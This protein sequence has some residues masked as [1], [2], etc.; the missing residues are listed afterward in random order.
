MQVV[1]YQF[2]NQCL[3]FICVV[4]R[5]L[6]QKN[7]V[8]IFRYFILSVQGFLRATLSTDSMH[9]KCDECIAWCNQRPH[10]MCQ[11]IEPTHHLSMQE[12]INACAIHSFIC[13]SYNTPGPKSA[14]NACLDLDAF[15][16]LRFILL[17]LHCRVEKEQHLVGDFIMSSICPFSLVSCSFKD[18]LIWGLL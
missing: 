17:L 5:R 14:N 9:V 10:P 6:C 4:K 1:F 16:K 12:K 8:I 3:V 11:F 18:L 15:C 7:D 2:A 13:N